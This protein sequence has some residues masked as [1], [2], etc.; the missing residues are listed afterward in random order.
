MIPRLPCW[1]FEHIGKTDN[2]PI[3]IDTDKDMT[4][5][6]AFL[7]GVNVSG[8]KILKM[9]YLREVFLSCGFKNVSTFIQSGNVIFDAAESDV[10]ALTKIV[11]D[12]LLKTLNYKVHA[13]L[14][15]F[16]ELTNMVK[17]DPFREFEAIENIKLYV[18]FLSVEPGKKLV[19]PMV[20]PKNDVE[21]FG[22]NM[23][24][25]YC[26]SRQ[27]N[28]SFGFPNLFIEKEFR[29]PATTRNWNT[30]CKISKL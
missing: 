14:R 5:Y 12:H 3:P 28:G 22:L 6:V 10:I 25:F 29:V 15:T 7:R 13:L 24:D 20:S 16:Q 21:I 8:Q 27:Q 23:L 30:I 1:D 2:D 18:T 26:I 19:L 11:E 9:E 17:S 4:R